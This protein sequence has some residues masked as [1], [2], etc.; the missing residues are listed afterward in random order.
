MTYCFFLSYTPKD[1]TFKDKY[2]R[3][4]VSIIRNQ[5]WKDVRSAVTPAFTTGKIKSVLF[6]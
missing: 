4:F 1:F 6:I 3:K 2:S 5:E